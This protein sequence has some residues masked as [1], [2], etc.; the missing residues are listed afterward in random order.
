MFDL[1]HVQCT[2]YFF[3]DHW[4]SEH[5]GASPEVKNQL[6]K[7]MLLTFCS[8]RWFLQHFLKKYRGYF[9]SS[10]SN[11][12][13]SSRGIQTISRGTKHPPFFPPGSCC[14]VLCL[15]LPPQQAAPAWPPTATPLTRHRGSCSSALFILGHGEAS[16][17]ECRSLGLSTN[18]CPPAHR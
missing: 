4:V 7:I 16:T 2:S 15:L 10:L 8:R 13:Y 5:A 14:C 6:Y 3:P 17:Q 11:P 9:L 1:I 12:I 18:V